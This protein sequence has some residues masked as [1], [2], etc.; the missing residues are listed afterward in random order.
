VSF[1][2][3]IFI[4]FIFWGIISVGQSLGESKVLPPFIAAWFANIIFGILAMVLLWKT[5]RY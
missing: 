1:A 3:A 5:R 2:L 4:I